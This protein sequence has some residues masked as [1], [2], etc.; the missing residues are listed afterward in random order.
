MAKY[1]RRLAL[2]VSS[3]PY[4]VWIASSA[5]ASIRRSEELFASAA[6]DA[7]RRRQQRHSSTA[8]TADVRFIS[9]ALAPLLVPSTSSTMVPRRLD[10]DANRPSLFREF[11]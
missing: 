5:S 4:A 6:F 1:G 10:R 8:G 9:A 7:C 11:V 3:K 2:R